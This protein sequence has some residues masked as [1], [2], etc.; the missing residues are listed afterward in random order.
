MIDWTKGIVAR[1]YATI[2][3]PN[4][5]RDESSFDIIG[6]SINYTNTGIRGSADIDCREFNHESEY[7][8]RLYLEASQNGESELI[9][10][11]T[12]LA[13]S[14]GISYNGRIQ[15]SKVQCFSVLSPAEKVYLPLG[16]F[17]RAGTNGAI[18]IKDLL[19][20]VIPAPVIIDGA[21]SSIT[22]NIV[23][24]NDET[25]LTMVDKILTAINWTIYLSGNGEVHISPFITDTVESFGYATNDVLEMSVSIANN[26]ADIPN[27]F[28]AVG[29]G[30]ASIA[31]DENPKSM[32]SIQNRGREI[33]A[34]E[35]NCVLNDGEKISDYA[36][37]R[38]KELQKVSKTIDYTRRFMPNIH[39]NNRVWL[40]YPEQN[41]SGPYIIES[42][43]I[44]IGY[45]SNVSEKVVSC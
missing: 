17:L 14:P 22:Q 26:W 27:V 42:Q 16:W 4:T 34:Q 29:S 19:K 44:N 20:D 24:E 37:R 13:S 33:W 38:L 28:R 32:F 25:V 1:N 8:V 23:A 41:I 35:T 40:N 30:I 39:V 45:G 21:S 31:K 7:W 5:W 11:F 36:T 2:V 12:G 10:L 3:D 9:P 15:E 43:T 18:G 6:G